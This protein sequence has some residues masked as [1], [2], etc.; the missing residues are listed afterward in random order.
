MNRH[1]WKGATMP[2]IFAVIVA[3]SLLS[4]DQ[5][6][7]KALIASSAFDNRPTSLGSATPPSMDIPAL[8]A[9]ARGAPTLICAIASQSVRG[10]GDWT[11]AP[12]TPLAIRRNVG[13][14][15]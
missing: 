3:A 2:K 5:N 15:D 12:V 10:F 13:T 8:M 7:D 4:S 9:A 6:P 11:D 1:N 14:L